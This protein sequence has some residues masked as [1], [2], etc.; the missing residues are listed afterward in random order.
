MKNQLEERRG[1]YQEVVGWCLVGPQ[2]PTLIVASE[3]AEPRPVAKPRGTEASWW[4][5]SRP[6]AKPRG[7]E[8]PKLNKGLLG[9]YNEAGDTINILKAEG[10]Q[11]PTFN[12]SD[13]MFT[14][15][16]AP[17]WADG[18]CC[19]GCRTQFTM[20]KRKH[21]CRACGQVFC[22]DCSSKSSTI[23]K[24]GIEREV[25]VCESCYDDINNGCLEGVVNLSRS[26]STESIDTKT[27]KPVGTLP[28]FCCRV[29]V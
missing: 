3:K 11:L 16:R 20:L 2:N 7:T 9:G 1:V 24:F 25:R 21:H 13:A 15:Y 6:V 23:P 5:E 18:E 27:I 28:I 26:S 19:H 10:Y 29:L 4:E 22:G 14:A 8:D 12:E 17:D